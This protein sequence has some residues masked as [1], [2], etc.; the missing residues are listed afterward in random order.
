MTFQWR[1]RSFHWQRTTFPLEP[2]GTL[3]EQI[4]LTIGHAKQPH[5]DGNDVEAC[6]KSSDPNVKR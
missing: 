3:V 2:A 5:H 4:P 1:G 6:N